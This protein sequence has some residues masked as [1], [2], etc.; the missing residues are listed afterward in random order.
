MLSYAPLYT[1]TL[2]LACLLALAACGGEESSN[3]DPSPQN[4]GEE[5]ITLYECGGLQI[6]LPT[7]HLPLLRVE[8]KF[9]GSEESWKPLISVYEKA[10]YETAEA[11][12]GGG[13]GFLFGFLVMN[14][15]AFEQ[16]ISA[17]GSGI[18]IFATDGG[19]YYAYTYPT[20]V[21]FC[22]PGEEINAEDWKTWEEL[23]ETGPAVQKDFLER[24]GLQSFSMQDFI[25]QL[26]AKSGDCLCIKY[27]PSFLENGDTCL[28]YQLLLRQPVRQGEGGIWAVEQWL[29]E[30][31][32]QYLYFPDTGRPA[33][34]YYAQLQG[35][36]D[37]GEYSEY[38][39]P[40][41]AAAAFVEDFFGNETAPGSFEEAQKIDQAYMDMNR[42]LEQMVLNIMFGREA[43][44]LELLNCLG[45]TTADSWGVLSRW[46]Y[47]SDWSEPLMEAVADAA[48]GKDQQAR[49]GAV[50][51]LLLAVQDTAADLQTPLYAV[52]QT[53]EQADPEAFAA[54]LSDLS[55]EDQ[56]L[57]SHALG[58]DP[59][60]SSHQP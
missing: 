43:D 21:Q 48:I 20:D 54:A 2:A 44:S 46:D 5:N 52:L 23:N 12:Y 34:E 37:T 58:P 30:Y 41:G 26:S 10:S 18:D 55:E 25:N 6:A 53:Q 28:Y 56:E 59:Q 4:A 50:M 60:L 35:E 36:C 45:N 51:S 39:T 8:A 31:G 13:G 49:D 42:R 1:F 11:E 24:N 47:G 14:Q 3:Q 22:R 7:Q 27:Y 33:A 17:D 15:A 38:R 40:V 16:H 29:D 9:P 19:R 57:L 32:N